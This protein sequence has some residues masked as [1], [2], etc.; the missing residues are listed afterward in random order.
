MLKA[1][2]AARRRSLTWPEALPPEQVSA[3]VVEL[4]SSINAG[5]SATQ[6]QWIGHVKILVSD[7]TAAAYGSLT[8][9]SD[10]PHWA[11]S[12]TQPLARAELTVYAAIY[13]ATDAQVAR[14]VDEALSAAVFV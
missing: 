11:G 12:L 7:G 5:L 6:P 4:L 14:A 2:T 3:H 13:G 1:G 8:A 9:A 10:Q